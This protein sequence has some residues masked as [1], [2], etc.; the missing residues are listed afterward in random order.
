M[1]SMK[2]LKNVKTYLKLLEHPNKYLIP[3][4]LTV[5]YKICTKLFSEKLDLS[6]S[7]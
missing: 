3:F 4:S 2:L 1:L 5:Y 7:Q 6:L